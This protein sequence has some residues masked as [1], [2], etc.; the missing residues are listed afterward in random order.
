MKTNA[1]WWFGCVAQLHNAAKRFFYFDADLCALSRALSMTLWLW[2]SDLLQGCLG[3]FVSVQICIFASF[4]CRLPGCR[5][6]QMDTPKLRNHAL[7]FS[8]VKELDILTPCQI[9][10]LKLSQCCLLVPAHWISWPVGKLVLFVH[11]TVIVFLQSW[12]L[13]KWAFGKLIDCFWMLGIAQ[14]TKLQ[15]LHTVQDNTCM[16]PRSLDRQLLTEYQSLETLY[17]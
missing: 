10:I 3:L 1:P 5:R 7:I 15:N 2:R 16:P 13:F 14:V 9:F 6:Q 8:I 17:N 11:L 12:L 4:V